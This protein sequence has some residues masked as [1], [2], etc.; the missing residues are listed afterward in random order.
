M[1]VA[2][3]KIGDVVAVGPQYG[4]RLYAVESIADGNLVVFKLDVRPI[5]KRYKLKPEQVV[6]VVGSVAITR[7]GGERQAPSVSH[8][9]RAMAYLRTLKY[10][11]TM[12]LQLYQRRRRYTRS[13]YQ[14]A[15]FLG[16][17]PRGRKYVFTASL[18]G[19]NVYKCSLD[20]VVLPDEQA[21]IGGDNVQ[22]KEKQS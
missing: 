8:D 13:P 17:V 1:N 14:P 3:I 2:D 10:G 4:D 6:I 21:A 20:I 18:A 19:G 11:D 12:T 16:L 15:T 9:D 5:G 7:L 22:A